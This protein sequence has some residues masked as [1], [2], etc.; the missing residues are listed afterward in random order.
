MTKKYYS[1]NRYNNYKTDTDTKSKTI[2]Q[3]VK[4]ETRSISY[5][6]IYNNKN[7]INNESKTKTN[8]I[9]TES[10]YIKRSNYNAKGTTN[11]KEG[12]AKYTYKGHQRTD[13]N[14]SS[15]K[16]SASVAVFKRRNNAY[17]GTTDNKNSNFNSNINNK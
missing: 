13:S 12:F 5:K 6:G 14:N 2:E 16:G 17:K 11:E 7:N 9:R 8:S 10:K 15:S 1:P 4:S 3:E